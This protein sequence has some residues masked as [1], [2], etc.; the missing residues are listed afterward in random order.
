[1]AVTAVAGEFSTREEQEYAGNNGLRVPSQVWYID[2]MISFSLTLQFTEGEKRYCHLCY[3][4]N[5]YLDHNRGL[6]DEPSSSLLT[7]RFP[8]CQEFPRLF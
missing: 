2:S 7:I 5:K 3:R 6:A 4:L 1:M 8:C